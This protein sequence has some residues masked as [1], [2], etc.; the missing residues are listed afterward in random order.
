MAVRKTQEIAKAVP[1]KSVVKIKHKT[2]TFKHRTI[3]ADENG[4]VEVT[5]AELES[6]KKMKLV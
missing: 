5:P 1:K 2:V 4:N 3:F 6:L